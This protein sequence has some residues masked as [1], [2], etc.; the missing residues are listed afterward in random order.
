MYVQCVTIYID[1]AKNIDILYKDFGE[2]I[3]KYSPILVGNYKLTSLYVF[4]VDSKIDIIKICNKYNYIFYELY[5]MEIED[6][7]FNN[8][9]TVHASSNLAKKYILL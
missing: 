5:V 7:M 8:K 1:N 9:Y 6:N 4:C 3:P 2:N